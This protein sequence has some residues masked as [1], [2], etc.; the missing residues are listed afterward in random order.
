[1]RQPLFFLGVGAIQYLLDAG[2]YALLI[3]NGVGTMPANVTSRATA[4][5]VGFVLN[6]YVTFRQRNET[7]KRL[8]TSLARFILF[9][10]LMTLVS[11]AS[12]LM[13][14]STWGDDDSHRIAAKLL[15]EAVLAVVSYLVSRFWVFRN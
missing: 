9:W 6:R 12:V 13:L 2:L 7:V 5:G 11:T 8:G 1:M 14:E 4:A 3:T 15:V 10:G